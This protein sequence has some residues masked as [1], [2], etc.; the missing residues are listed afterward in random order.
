MEGINNAKDDNSIPLC[1]Y[2]CNNKNPSHDSAKL[3]V[4]YSG[5]STITLVIQ[6]S[7]AV[8]VTTDTQNRIER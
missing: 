8:F 1:M 4:S 5:Q 2:S 3:M 6:L 7:H